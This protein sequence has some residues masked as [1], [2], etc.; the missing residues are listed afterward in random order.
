MTTRAG[1][2]VLTRTDDGLRVE[3]ADPLILIDAAQVE[4]WRR[5]ED[6]ERGISWK[7]DVLRIEGT[8]RTVV[9]RLGPR[10]DWSTYLAEWPD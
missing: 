7:D 6:F 8:N 1:D 3:R 4:R 10:H 9:Y 5:G 2:C